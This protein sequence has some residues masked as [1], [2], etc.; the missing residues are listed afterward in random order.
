MY[1]LVELMRIQKN[2]YRFLQELSDQLLELS[3]APEM[4]WRAG[5]LKQV[6][7][8]VAGICYH[9]VNTYDR[10]EL[11]WTSGELTGVRVQGAKYKISLDNLDYGD[12]IY[13]PLSDVVMYVDT[14]EDLEY[15]NDNYY[16]L[17]REE[18]EASV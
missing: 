9:R 12:L 14:D 15:A 13:N 5:T 18:E 3:K 7:N 1:N 4:A 6:A 10:F 16:K 2:K 8:T 17:V 11:L